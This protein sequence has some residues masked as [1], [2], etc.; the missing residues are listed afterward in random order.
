MLCSCIISR[1]VSYLLCSCIISRVYC[2]LK[3]G[4]LEDINVNLVDYMLLLN[5]ISVNPVDY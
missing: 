1:V 5:K 3:M 2:C 4:I